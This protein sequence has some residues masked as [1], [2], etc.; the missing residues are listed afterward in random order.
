MERPTSTPPSVRHHGELVEWAREAGIGAPFSQNP[1]DQ[2]LAEHELMRA[3]LSAMQVEAL[4]VSREKDLRFDFWGDAVDF[5]GNFGLLCHYRRKANHLFPML[6]AAGLADRVQSLDAEQQSNIELTL[7]LCDVVQEADWEQVI[8]LVALYVGARRK[9]MD[10][11]ERELL[12][13]AK[14][15]LGADQLKSLVEAFAEVD[16]RALHPQGRKGYL[17]IA[18]KLA[19]AVDQ[20]DPLEPPA[21]TL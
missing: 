9:Q 12:V 3:V 5:V 21:R 17:A 14:E 16:Q 15:Q 13:A 4:R 7:E 18:Q 11:E 19:K 2:L 6:A 8:R 10:R 1:I 20:R